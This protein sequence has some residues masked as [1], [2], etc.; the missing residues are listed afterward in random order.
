MCSDKPDENHPVFVADLYYQ[1]ILVAA[2]IEN[3]P[4]VFKD[5]G[6]AVL[7][8]DVCRACPR[9]SLKFSMPRF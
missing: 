2:D 4:A 7:L 5:A 9:G 3:H 1:P 6:A 8:F